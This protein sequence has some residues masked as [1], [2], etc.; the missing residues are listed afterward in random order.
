MGKSG[1]SRGGSKDEG[2]Q[3]KQTLVSLNRQQQPIE[4]R[5]GVYEKLQLKLPDLRRGA[6]GGHGEG[7]GGGVVDEKSAP[8]LGQQPSL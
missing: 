3:Q 4:K 6:K 8:N 1:P 2:Q 7:Q 5:A